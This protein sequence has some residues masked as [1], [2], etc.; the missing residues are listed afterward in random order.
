[1][2]A[3]NCMLSTHWVD[4]YP[5]QC[6]D[7]VVT[8]LALAADLHHV[9]LP[10]R[11]AVREIRLQG[12]RVPQQVCV[13]HSVHSDML[14]FLGKRRR[15]VVEVQCGRRKLG[16]VNSPVFK[17]TEQLAKQDFAAVARPSA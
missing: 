7:W 11:I 14:T 9:F 17:V 8:G 6:T 15:A 5:A 13:C 4:S 3:I 2:H 12:F 16:P 1:M 10:Q